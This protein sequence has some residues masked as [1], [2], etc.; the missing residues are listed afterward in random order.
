MAGSSHKKYTQYLPISIID[1]HL[2]SSKEY[3]EAM[4]S[5]AIASLS[6]L[7]DTHRA[8]DILQEWLQRILAAIVQHKG[9]EFGS[10]FIH[11]HVARNL[12][13]LGCLKEEIT[14]GVGLE[15]HS[16]CR[17]KPSNNTEIRILLQ[18]Y[19]TSNVHCY[20]PGRKST[21]TDVS[22][23]TQF[24]VGLDSFD[25]F[26]RKH[27][28]RMMFMRDVEFGMVDAGDVEDAVD[29][30]DEYMSADAPIYLN[31][32]Q[33][34]DIVMHEMDSGAD[35]RRI[36]ANLMNGA[37]EADEDEDEVDNMDEVGS[38]E[39]DDNFRLRMMTVYVNNIL[40]TS[41]SIL[42][43]YQFDSSRVFRNARIMM[44]L[45]V[46]PSSLNCLTSGIRRS[47]F[48]YPTTSYSS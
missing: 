35:A 32:V 18:E 42:Y 36:V 28:K 41:T 11:N 43:L 16:Q 24:M 10:S 44:S 38:M 21:D 37:L 2:E 33:D 23:K 1:L 31:T 25:G 6:G 7:P 47:S 46:L 29:E 17:S 9:Q 14:G 39:V 13:E 45:T 20:Q 15:K 4:L 5:T 22:L 40:I 27:T 12:R 8:V 26:L 34:G 19:Q 3:R 30:D 48:A